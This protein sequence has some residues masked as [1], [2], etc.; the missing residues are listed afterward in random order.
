ML[1][2]LRRELEKAAELSRAHAAI[3]Y[4]ALA[5]EGIYKIDK[6]RWWPVFGPELV[7]ILMRE[8]VACPGC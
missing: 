7:R 3:V 5:R 4:N 1:E 8:E 6:G 2:R